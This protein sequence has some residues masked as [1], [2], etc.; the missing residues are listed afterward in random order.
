MGTVRSC[1]VLIVTAVVSVSCRG[2]VGPS[3]TD[4]SGDVL[5]SE[6]ITG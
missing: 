4:E 5:R 1:G 3:C 2:I 6:G